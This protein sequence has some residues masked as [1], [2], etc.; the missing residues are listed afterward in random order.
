MTISNLIA[1]A[2]RRTCVLTERF[3]GIRELE[4]I[5]VQL[6]Y[7]SDYAAG[8]NEGE[9][10]RDINIGVIAVREVEPRD[11]ELA[12]LLYE[13]AEWVRKRRGESGWPK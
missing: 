11:E 6:D 5:R 12:E 1:D 13:V 2:K 8:K 4:S 10:L 7:L 3:P 9:R